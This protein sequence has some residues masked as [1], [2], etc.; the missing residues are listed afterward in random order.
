[1]ES[2]QEIQMA[3]QCWVGVTALRWSSTSHMQGSG[4]IPSDEKP[5]QLNKYVPNVISQAE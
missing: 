1:M 4:L 2:K 3:K 5:S